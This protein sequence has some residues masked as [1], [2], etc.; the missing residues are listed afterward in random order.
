MSI[1]TRGAAALAVSLPLAL[2]SAPPAAAQTSFIDQAGRVVMLEAPAKRLITL[3]AATP[4]VYF[5][6]DGTTEHIAGTTS[7][8][9]RTFEQGYYSQTIPELSAIDTSMGG[10][11][12][13]T[14]VE[15]ILAAA[16]DLV[17]QVAHKDGL[18]QQLEDVGLKVAGWNCCTEEQ[19]RGY[20]T[21]SGYISGR[22]DRA[23]MILGMQDASNAALVEH[24]K[25]VEPAQY[26][27]MLEVDKIGEQIQVVANSSQNYA[28]SGVSNLAADDTGEWWRTIDAEQF[29]VWNPEVIIIPAWATDLTPQAFYDDPI[30]GSVDAIKN[31]RV[32]KVPKFNRSPDAPE[33]HLTAQWLARITHPTDF[34]DETAFRDTL[35]TTFKEIYGKDLSDAQLGAILEVEANSV[36]ADYARFSA[37]RSRRHEGHRVHR[38][39]R[40]GSPCD[41]RRLQRA[42]RRHD[43]HHGTG[44]D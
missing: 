12:N 38:L 21:M 30:L 41:L 25:G 23:Q 33:V 3:S 1:F 17:V 29:L 4:L 36:S 15:A 44:G 32:Y 22:N 10:P 20:L 42:Y 35:K 37:D 8:S 7:A 6:V 11:S 16:P 34:A 39:G 18:I 31:R 24:F 13:A 40:R 27:K 2:M 43:L 28:L 26:V 9:T 14:N 19:R 5:A